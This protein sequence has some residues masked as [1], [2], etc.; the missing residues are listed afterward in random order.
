MKTI[1]IGI[2]DTDSKYGMCTTYVG[3]IAIS[4]LEDVG[5]KLVET[6]HLI[7]LNPNWIKKTRGNCSVSFKVRTEEYKIP[8]VKEIVL[9]TVEDLAEL[10]IEETTPGVVFYQSDEIPDKLKSYSRKT[11]QEV[12]TIEQAEALAKDIGAEFH[13]FREGRGIIG[14]L[15]AIGHPLDKDYTYE[16][17]AYR[18][19]ENRGAPRKIDKKSVEKMN[20]KMLPKTFDNL[21]DETGEVSITP[22]TPCPILYGIRSDS[23]EAA[24]EAQEIVREEEPI[25]RT[26][27]YKTNQATDEHFQ[28]STVSGIEPYSSVIVEGTVSEE[29]ETITGGHVFFSIKDETGGVRCA[30]FE[31][32]GK[33]REVVRRVTPGDRVRVYGG[34]KKK[35]NF[36]TTINL[37]KMEILK[38]T[39]IKK[40]T[41]ITCK[42]CGKNVKSA[43]EGKGYYCERCGVELPD[44][45]VEEI[46]LDRDLE[47]GVYE[48]PPRA[49]R[50]L[51]KPLI[52]D[53]KSE[54]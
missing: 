11:V 48:V 36:P 37:E 27:L 9:E 4:K 31:P 47:T 50:H 19:E 39:P 24:F 34:V 5:A 26:I 35:S 54:N 33:F 53:E 38:L 41:N 12:V 16:I 42:S 32:T 25:E 28:P 21:D 46:E 1:I 7:R 44:G 51:T 10:Q 22:H 40:R 15:A 8:R 6:P 45:A 30:A 20:E 3:A 13:K 49:R 43:G 29:P 23:P 14:A 17:I 52:R 18:T 2:D